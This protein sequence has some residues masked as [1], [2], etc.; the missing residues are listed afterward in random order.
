MS[1]DSRDFGFVPQS[2][3]R[4]AP[5]FIFWP[6]GPRWGMPNQ[7]SYPLI[8]FPGVIVWA[9]AGCCIITGSILWRRKN[10]LPLLLDA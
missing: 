2:N 5:D 8:T 7:P 9:A 1:S 3:V 10:N 4:G 6:P